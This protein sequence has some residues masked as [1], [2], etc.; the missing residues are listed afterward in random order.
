MTDNKSV[1]AFGMCGSFCT[2]EKVFAELEKLAL[3]YDIL[4]IMSEN[5]KSIDTRFGKAE[6]HVKR[7]E[8]ITKKKVLSKI[9]ETEPIGPLKLADV[10]VI[11]PCT[12]N[13]LAKIANAIT[14][15]G[16]TM[17]AKSQL[18]AKR[19][20]ILA[21]SSNDI[22]GINMENIG[23]LMATKNLY[24]VPFK[25]DDP[26]RKENSAVADFSLIENTIENALAGK[27]L[28]PVLL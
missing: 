8:D 23:R 6:E 22:L 26:Q 27:Q 18:R 1:V 17:A 5:A 7:M 2:F 13:T 9:E 4:P 3:K 24:F 15:T 28:Q 25:Q 16:V 20:V 21:V 19:P 14:D 11:A 10:Y 12:G